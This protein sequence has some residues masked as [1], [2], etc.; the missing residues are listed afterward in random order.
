MD[1]GTTSNLTR[2]D[3]MASSA[4]MGEVITGMVLK[5]QSHTATDT[6]TDTDTENNIVTP[7]MQVLSSHVWKHGIACNSPTAVPMHHPRHRLA[8]PDPRG[9]LEGSRLRSYRGRGRTANR[10]KIRSQPW[11]F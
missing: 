2:L 11:K 5:R 8:Y 10:R 7:W 4:V 3:R 6:D 1:T 9:R